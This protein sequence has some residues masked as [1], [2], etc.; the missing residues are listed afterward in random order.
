MELTRPACSG[1]R[2][3]IIACVCWWAGAAQ[4]CQAGGV[5]ITPLTRNI[6]ASQT[7]LI[8]AA[9]GKAALPIVISSKASDS[10]KAIAAELAGYLSRMS[11][12]EFVVKTGD[13]AKGIVLGTLGE[14]PKIG[15]AHV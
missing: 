3:A 11:G 9:D 8:L 13:G 2:M 1:I 14:F 10:T 12:A 7:T 4:V 15:R 6:G 5:Y